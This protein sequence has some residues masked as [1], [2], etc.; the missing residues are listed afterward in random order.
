M[1]PTTIA[2][3]RAT[4]RGSFGE[5]L[6]LN[7]GSLPGLTAYRYSPYT[8]PNAAAGSAAAAA[9]LAAAASPP[10]SSAMLSNASVSSVVTS[11]QQ[12]NAA[13][14]HAQQQQHQ[15]NI[16][17]S[18]EN[19]Q[20]LL[21]SCIAAGQLAAQHG[22][23]L[24]QL[25]L[26]GLVGALPITTAVSSV[27]AP[28]QQAINSVAGGGHQGANHLA[29]AQLLAL[30]NQ[31]VHAAAAAAAAAAGSC[32]P[33]TLPSIA[34]HSSNHHHHHQAMNGLNYSM[35]DLINLQGLQSFDASANFQVPV[36][37]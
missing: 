15:L 4:A 20:S 11:H 31:A 35:N 29:A 23:S 6:M 27:S 3:G 22:F 16:A 32:K 33:R 19:G 24:Q 10:S 12:Q 1:L 21:N 2:R 28:V 34:D 25:Q 7:P 8:I 5:L 26:L 37:L 9:A 17:A 36:G 14:A 13:Q 30:N 18:S